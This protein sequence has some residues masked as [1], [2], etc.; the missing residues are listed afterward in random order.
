MPLSLE[1]KNKLSE[2]IDNIAEIIRRETTSYLKSGDNRHKE[3]CE[4]LKN[5]RFWL[6]Q[7][8]EQ[9]DWTGTFEENVIHYCKSAYKNETDP[10]IKESLGNAMAKITP[11]RDAQMKNA[12]IS[13]AQGTRASKSPFS[14]LPT[15]MA[16]KIVSF[17]GE[18]EDK[19]HKHEKKA[20]QNIRN[21]IAKKKV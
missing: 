21:Q 15:N 20:T 3:V 2:T 11:L 19:D 8:K 5:Y 13:I 17:F 7:Y 4:S 1:F 6:N 16:G 12:T 18:G 10:Q 9:A 14:K